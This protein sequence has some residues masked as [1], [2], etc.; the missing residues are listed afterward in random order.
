MSDDG[1]RGLTETQARRRARNQVLFREVNNRIN[2]LND[3]FGTD[4]YAEFLCEC[5]DPQCNEAVKMTLDEYAAVRQSP[6]Q[7]LSTPGHFAQGVDQV[8]MET[9]RFWLLA[10]LPGTPTEVATETAS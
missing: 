8:V 3:S 9:E 6:V 1:Q 10:T 5:S 4:D 7:F 2:D